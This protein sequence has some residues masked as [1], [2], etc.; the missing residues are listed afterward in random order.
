MKRRLLSIILLAL[1]LA[2]GTWLRTEVNVGFKGAV[3]VRQIAGQND[4]SIDG[5]QLHGVW[6]Y[7]A[8]SMAFGGYSALLA[9][10]SNKLRAFSDR[11]TR[12][13]LIEP[14]QPEELTKN[15]T[16]GR[17]MSRQLVDPEY[18]F[19]LWD[20]ESATRDPKT[21]QYW[22]GFENVHAFQRY[23][24]ASEPEEVRLITDEVD[25]TSNSGAEAMVR[26]SD[27]RFLIIPEGG[28][29]GLLYP[30][31]PVTGV[32][33][34]SFVYRTPLPGFGITDAA[35][36]P[37]G[38]LLILSRNVT[39][40]IPP[41]EAR[42]AIAEIPPPGAPQVMSPRV[43]LDLTS[44]APPENYEGL[45]IRERA[46]GML[47]IWLISDDNLSAI[48]RTLLVKLRFDPAWSAP[49]PDKEKVAGPESE[50]RQPDDPYP[51]Q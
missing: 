11:G 33:A 43:V 26:L 35:Q 3:K 20:I 14:D 7:D 15:I 23:N 27:G 9:L 18:S 39:W 42:L 4:T 5:W 47:D 21:G 36:L 2:P 40:G 16:R 48:Q 24:V 37:D 19:Y 17:Q 28:K 12:F 6:E 13:T 25:W 34:Q 8:P 1:T 38:R 10:G 32:T 29:Q 45:A 22:L 50:A 46:D 41:F 49:V 31:D 30:D 51:N 44:L